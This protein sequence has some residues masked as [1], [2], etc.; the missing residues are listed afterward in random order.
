MAADRPQVCRLSPRAGFARLDA[1]QHD[2]KPLSE[3][4]SVRD[5]GGPRV[6]A[7]GSKEVEIGDC[8]GP[9]V[10]SVRGWECLSSLSEQLDVRVEQI[11]VGGHAGVRLHGAPILGGAAA[12]A[13]GLRVVFRDD[14]EPPHPVFRVAEKPQRLFFRAREAAALVEALDGVQANYCDTEATVA[15]RRASTRPVTG[16][17]P[18]EGKAPLLPL[19]LVSAL[20]DVLQQAWLMV[21]EDPR[22]ESPYAFGVHH[23]GGDFELFVASVAGLESVV[24]GVQERQAGDIRQILRREWRHALPGDSIST[25]LAELLRPANRRWERLL[26]VSRSAVAEALL[27][28][29]VARRAL[30]QLDRSGLF[31]AA[32]ENLL[33]E[34]IDTRIGGHGARLDRAAELNPAGHLQRFE[35]EL[36]NSRGVRG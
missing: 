24:E 35:R 26:G 27:R 32:R 25:E 29:F 8:W 5:L 16:H 6:L 7:F 31:G 34:V 14:F 11:V 10:L 18:A 22:H 33:L 23:T 19:G 13:T 17:L 28:D 30:K 36:A 12:D 9:S 1:A 21:V 3:L 20:R 15:A 4:N 2:A